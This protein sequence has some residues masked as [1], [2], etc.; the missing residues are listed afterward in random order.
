MPW[1][2]HFML[3][4]L[5]ELT[6]LKANPWKLY[7]ALVSCTRKATVV[8]IKLNPQNKDQA[9]GS[10]MIH[11]GTRNTKQRVWPT[12]DKVQGHSDKQTN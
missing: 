1:K 9:L 12:Q 7:S 8:V 5:T 3:F 10:K 2:K 11:P 6:K 4:F